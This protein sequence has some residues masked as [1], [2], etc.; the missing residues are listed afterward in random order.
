[1]LKEHHPPQPMDVAAAVVYLASDATAAIEGA[2]LV[3]Q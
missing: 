1:V 3:A 2:M